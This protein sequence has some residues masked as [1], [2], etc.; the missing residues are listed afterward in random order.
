[1]P[2]IFLQTLGDIV[3]W[4]SGYTFVNIYFFSL[5]WHLDKISCDGLFPWAKVYCAVQRCHTASFGRK[6][7]QRQGQ[8]TKTL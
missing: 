7:E 8:K 1:M 3:A 4:L 5:L 6:M 2:K